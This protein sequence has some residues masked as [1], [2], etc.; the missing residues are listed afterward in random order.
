LETD[1]VNLLIDIGFKTKTILKWITLK[2]YKPCLSLAKYRAIARYP[3]KED[4]EKTE[5]VELMYEEKIRDR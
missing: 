2:P 1:I 5:V 3:K 4:G